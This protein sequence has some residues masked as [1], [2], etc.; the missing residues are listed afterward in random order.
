MCIRDRIF[1]S[2]VHF[3]GSSLVSESQEKAEEYFNNNVLASKNLV[4]TIDDYIMGKNK[5][6]KQSEKGVTYAEKILKSDC[7]L[8]WKENARKLLLK[9]RGLNPYPGVWFYNN[10]N[11]RIKV[12]DAKI[13]KIKSDFVSGEVIGNLIIGCGD[14]ALEILTVKPEGKNIMN[15]KDYLRGNPFEIGEIL[16]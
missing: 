16:K 2:I 7:R 1:S 9:I 5:P 6:I 14:N 3:A 15:I 8:D 11:K 12:L 10:K 4:K 13:V